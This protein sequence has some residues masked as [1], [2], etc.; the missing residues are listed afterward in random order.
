MA[1]GLT[2]LLSNLGVEK[3]KGVVA[4]AVNVSKNGGAAYKR[5]MT[6]NGLGDRMSA[7]ISSG[8][9][10]VSKAMQSDEFKALDQA[11]QKAYSD[12]FIAAQ[13]LADDLKGMNSTKDVV[14]TIAEGRALGRSTAVYG[15][16]FSDYVAASK[17]V[18]KDYFWTG[19]TKGQRAARIGTVAAG[20]GVA[21][22][23]A[24]YISGGSA[25]YN[26]KGERDIAGIPFM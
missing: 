21:T 9:E 5:A 11:K 12:Q 4:N 19:A 16:K 14:K 2:K 25:Q 3:G 20:Y 10:G 7:K 18:A 1:K 8:F 26:S 22:G 15:P 17:E 23:T 6:A 24:R 13:A